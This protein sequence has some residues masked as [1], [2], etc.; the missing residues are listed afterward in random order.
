MDE[1]LTEAVRVALQWLFAPLLALVALA[2]LC[3]W[4]KA[5]GAFDTLGAVLRRMTPLQRW[6]F[7][8]LAA[9]CIAFGGDKTNSPPAGLPPVLPP[10]SMVLPIIGGPSAGIPGP[11]RDT[12]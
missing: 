1:G 2:L 6:G 7:C 10:L 9:A 12:A 5:S 4:I 8:M 3:V 11:G